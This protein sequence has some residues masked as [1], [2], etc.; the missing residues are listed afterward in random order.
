MTA[1]RRDVEGFEAESPGSEPGC[2]HR[3]V[4]SVG[5]LEFAGGSTGARKNPIE[6]R[7]GLKAGATAGACLAG[8]G[9][10]EFGAWRSCPPRGG[11]PGR[12]ARRSR[13]EA[14]DGKAQFMRV[15]DVAGIPGDG[16]EGQVMRRPVNRR[17]PEPITRTTASGRSHKAIQIERPVRDWYLGKATVEAPIS[18]P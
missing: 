11:V 2:G 12:S 15:A 8:A 16:G 7:S 3:F 5:A 9:L 1:K 14:G 6:G 10:A 17:S 18:S 13:S 4:D